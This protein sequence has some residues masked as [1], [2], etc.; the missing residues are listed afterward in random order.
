MCV[1]LSSRANPLLGLS[2]DH[3][4]MVFVNPHAG[5]GVGRRHIRAV[6]RLLS[7]A[8]V[9]ARFICT[10]SAQEMAFHARAA[11]G[12]G[13]ALLFVMGGDGTLQALV[14]AVHGSDVILGVLPAGGG[15]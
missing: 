9:P 2:P 6:Q 11:I 5:S 14:N 13:G 3:P 12:A 1:L 10:N 7:R 4:V 15:N 8:G